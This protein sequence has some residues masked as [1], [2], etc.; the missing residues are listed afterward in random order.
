MKDSKSRISGWIHQQTLVSEQIH[1]ENI[2][3]GGLE[4]CFLICLEFLDS[5]RDFC[6]VEILRYEFNGV[7]VK[8]KDDFI[9]IFE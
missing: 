4:E 9:L 7:S 6:L 5:I 8:C 1:L 2:V 3:I